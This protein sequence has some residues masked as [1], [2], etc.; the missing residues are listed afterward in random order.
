MKFHLDSALAEWRRELRMHP[1]I[2]PSYREELES[3]L[4]DRMDDLIQEGLSE[5][6]AF[7]QASQKTLE[8][9]EELADEYYKVRAVSNKKPRWKRKDDPL[10]FLPSHLFFAY[11]KQALRSFRVARSYFWINLLGLTLGIAAT[12]ILV[13]YISFEWRI[14]QFHSTYERIAF[15]TIQETPLSVP[16]LSDPSRFKKDF[17]YKDYSFIDAHTGIMVFPTPISYQERK[18]DTKV[19][20][21]DSNF[22]DVFEF[23]LM[24]GAKGKLLKDPT[25]AFLSQTTARRIFGREDPLGKEIQFEGETYFVKG[26]LD[27]PKNQSSIQFD[28]LVSRY[29]KS[30]WE[31]MGFECV[32]LKPNVKLEQLNEMAEGLMR[33]SSGYA[34]SKVR[35][36]W[37]SDLYY[38]K[39]IDKDLSYGTLLSGN[40]QYEKILGII[41][42][43]ILGISLFNYLNIY[44]VILLKRNKEFGVR[45]VLGAGNKELIANFLTENLLNSLM[46]VGLAALLI[47][48]FSSTLTQFL[49]KNIFQ[50]YQLD[51]WFLLTI[52]LGLIVL[53][54]LYPSVRYPGIHP[55]QAINR[56]A[57]PRKSLVGRKLLMTLQFVLTIGLL[58]VSLFFGKQ[59]YFMMNKDLG[60]SAQNVVQ[61]QYFPNEIPNYW[62]TTLYGTDEEEAKKI[63][64]K[65]E[66]ER[67][68]QVN[69]V[70]SELESIPFI[71]HLTYGD[72]PLKSFEMPWK[73]I[74]G[75]TEY[76]TVATL[77][78]TPNFKE[79]YGLKLTEGRFF[80]EGRDQSRSPKAVINE[81]ARSFFDIETIEGAT[82]SNSSWGEWDVIG[83]VED[84][85]FQHLSFG[86]KPLVILFFDDREQENCMARLQ[87]G[88]E[89]EG[90]AAME[91]LFLE[92]NPKDDFQYS[93]VDDEIG[94]MYA[95]D[96]RV[97]GIYALFSLIALIISA[98]G[99]FS[100]SSYD[101]HLRIKEIGIRKINGASISQILSL[102][103]GN[104]LRYL[105]IAVCIACPLASLAVIK[106]LEGFAHRTHF[107]L[108]VFVVA[109]GF[110]L[111]IAMLT[112][113]SHSYRA[114]RRNPIE[115][116]RYE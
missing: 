98:M 48:S 15:A 32:T 62:N 28:A 100:I 103:T 5:E 1:G 58:I 21:A 9:V 22:F 60:F 96:R 42:L 107:S 97:V 113:W 19:W 77:T 31:R 76:H 91:S 90:L 53:T 2:E 39:T 14:D 74:E 94:A 101:V 108:W 6:A 68:S 12:L 104:F 87:E 33:E 40:K 7:F 57:T 78:S 72:N 95:E 13:K 93:F 45:K 41:A 102:L 47:V 46:A 82:L 114:A 63:Y 88:R 105:I 89:K 24:D 18:Y 65:L 29:P 70:S 75:Q 64:E 71:T 56:F 109:I 11:L 73:N 17:H 66:A 37:F 52:L 80:E 34:E 8:C 50:D 44:S 10:D 4:L 79:L 69:Y 106:Y 43:M 112:M 54:T 38:A 83:V 35:F 51:L 26:I 111:S 99:L 110:T 30:F 36:E 3:N 81:A 16:Q 61:V 86:I 59:L 20:V 84:F 23:P 55:I 92:V 116:L 115:A 85:A 49:Q 67:E 25:C 27:V